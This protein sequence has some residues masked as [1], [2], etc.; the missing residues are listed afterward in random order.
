MIAD[1]KKKQKADSSGGKIAFQAAGILFM[2]II[3]V[4]VISDIKIYQKRQEL[5]L[6]IANYQK[7]IEDIRNSSKTLKD[8]IT[9]S[10]NQ[11]YI[12]KIAYEQLGEQKPGENEVIFIT[13]PDKKTESN[14]QPQNSSWM[15]WLSGKWNWIK[16]EL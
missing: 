14:P 13:P 2:A 9:N 8:E 5:T 11:D 1:F 16:N 6:E 12:E 15:S 7:Q 10:N 4:L 3:A